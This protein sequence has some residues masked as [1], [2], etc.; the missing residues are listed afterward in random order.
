MI[1]KAF[2]PCAGFAKSTASTLCGLPGMQPAAEFSTLVHEIAHL[3]G[4]EIYVALASRCA[5]K[6]VVTF[7]QAPH[8]LTRGR[9]EEVIWRTAVGADESLVFGHH[10]AFRGRVPNFQLPTIHPE[11]RVT[12]RSRFLDNGSGSPSMLAETDC[13]RKHRNP[14]CGF[15]SKIAV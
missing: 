6:R 5:K 15:D 11:R 13:R 9:T 12:C 8:N 3:C 1:K 4:A 14:T 7:D 2:F 10:R